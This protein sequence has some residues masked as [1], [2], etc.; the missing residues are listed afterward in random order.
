MSTLTMTP[1]KKKKLWYSTYESHKI[2]E[3]ESLVVELGDNCLKRGA[4]KRNVVV[5]SNQA[6]CFLCV[7][8]S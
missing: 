5:R 8:S 4:D 7:S 2:G 1:K 3:I 6:C